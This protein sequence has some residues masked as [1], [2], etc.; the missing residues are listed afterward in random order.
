MLGDRPW[1]GVAIDL[2]FHF[3]S[4]DPDEDQARSTIPR[5]VTAT[6]PQVSVPDLV[7]AGEDLAVTVELKDTTPRALKVAVL[8]ENGRQVESRSPAISET[9]AIKFDGLAPGAYYVQVSGISVGAPVVP[10]TSAVLV[11][12]C[13]SV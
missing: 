1:P 2:R 13:P 3:A 4:C 5:N 8:D 9:M 11:M 12:D 6:E 10:V 7:L